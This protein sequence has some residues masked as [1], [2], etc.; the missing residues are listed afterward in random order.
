MSQPNN[1][2][3]EE[4][5]IAHILRVCKNSCTKCFGVVQT[6][7]EY[8]KI[9]YK[10]YQIESRKKQFGVDFYQL[11]SNPNT[12]EAD[13]QACIDAVLN[14]TAAVAKEIEVL[15]Q[16]IERVKQ[17]TQE[18][19]VSKPGTTTTTTTAAAPTTSAAVEAPTPNPTTTTTT[20]PTS[21]APEVSTGVEVTPTTS[22]MV[23]DPTMTEVPL[24]SNTTTT[25][26]TN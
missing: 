4:G 18:K 26:T 15:K 8:A 12:T 5:L 14:D 11:V 7:D 13:K 19:I 22:P 9:K 17:S 24:T 3:T 21:T 2:N 16:E 23:E 6:T 20:A 10:E 1:N 25:T